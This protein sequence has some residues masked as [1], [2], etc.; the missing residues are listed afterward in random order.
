MLTPFDYVH[1]PAN[2][3]QGYRAASIKTERLASLLNAGQA[4]ILSAGLTSIL[5]TAV[6]TTV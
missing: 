2:S 6:N 4:L 5:V 3:T 1:P